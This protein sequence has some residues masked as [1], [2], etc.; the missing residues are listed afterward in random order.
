MNFRNN[1]AFTEIKTI[2]ASQ[3]IELL[4]TIGD[5]ASGFVFEG[6]LTKTNQPCAVKI[7]KLSTKSATFANEVTLSQELRGSKSI[8]KIFKAFANRKYGFL[9]MEKLDVDLLDFITENNRLCEEDALKIFKQICKGVKHCHDKNIAHLD[10]KPENVLLKFAK[11]NASAISSI[12]LCDFGHSLN[13]QSHIRRKDCKTVFI[14]NTLNNIGTVQYRAPEVNDTLH[15]HINPTACDMWS[16]G[17]MLFVMMTGYF[18][19]SEIPDSDEQAQLDINI[20]KQVATPA[21]CNLL[22]S[23]L[24][25][26]PSQRP[27]IDAVL[28]HKAFKPSPFLSRKKSCL[29]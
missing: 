14:P 3:G 24:E 1:L 17:I 9:A 23:L 26:N 19:F 12:K 20:F 5:G 15:S 21:T 2:C 27:T 7:S 16:L 6:I 18:P 22:F 25:E 4:D 8:T 29:N 28:S 10:L 13:F 11:C